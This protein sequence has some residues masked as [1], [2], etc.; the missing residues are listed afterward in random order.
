MDTPV[1]INS[2]LAVLDRDEWFSSCAE[3]LKHA[4]VRDAKVH[5]LLAGEALYRDGE[6][7]KHALFCVIGGAIRLSSSL[8][9]GTPSLLVYLEPCHWFGDIS[10]I[11]GQPYIRDA[12]ADIDAQILCVPMQSFTQWL[13]QNPKHWRDIARLSINKL[14]VAYQVIGE[15]GALQ[16]RLAR[17]L[18][19]MAHGFG[20][21]MHS[22]TMQLSVSQEHLAQMMGSTRQSINAALAK[23]EGLGLLSQGYKSID[24]TNLERLLNH[25]NRLDVDDLVDR[26]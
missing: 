6:F 16:H 12:I 8:H 11:D 24:L 4:L 21:R 20:S 7:A 3:E 14:R 19:L 10:L 18:W 13:E 1:D 26:P 25:A 17:R 5:R 23:L 22:P 2:L 9:D 15:P